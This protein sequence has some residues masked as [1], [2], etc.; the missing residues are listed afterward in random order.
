[1]S[2]KAP[3]I[4]MSKTIPNAYPDLA[5]HRKS[6]YNER[7]RNAHSLGLNFRY[8][9]QPLTRHGSI[10]KKYGDNRYGVC[11]CCHKNARE[12]ICKIEVVRI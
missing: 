5:V 11:L 10:K 9:N 4:L 2:K 12:C 7:V 8:L 3:K 1:M 6:R